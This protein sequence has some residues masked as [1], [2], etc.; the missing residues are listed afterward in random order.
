MCTAFGSTC[1]D[2]LLRVYLPW[3]QSNMR[4]LTDDIMEWLS[5]RLS[6]DDM[7]HLANELDIS[8]HYFSCLAEHCQ[9]CE[10]QSTNNILRNWLRYQTSR[11]EAYILMGNA[12]RHPDVGLNLIAREVLDYPPAKQRSKKGKSQPATGTNMRNWKG[13]KV[14][15]SYT[16]RWYF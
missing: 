2:I 8:P 1:V 10:F 16:V 14:P 7:E 13:P 6:R 3:L 5:Q 4:A 12:L 11:E 15:I 9:Q